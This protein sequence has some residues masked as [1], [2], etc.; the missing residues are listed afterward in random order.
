M[1]EAG[2][3]WGQQVMP[4]GFAEMLL[5]TPSQWSLTSESA[6]ICLPIAG[7]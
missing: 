5:A 1:I 7:I 3:D 2:G 6:E 4:F